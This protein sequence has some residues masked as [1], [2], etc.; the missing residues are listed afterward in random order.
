MRELT[1]YV[2]ATADG[3]IARVDGSFD[4]FLWEGEHLTDL[5]TNFPE[6]IPTHLR[7][8]LNVCGENRRY[9]TVLMG[10][11]TYEVG[12][13]RG[14]TSPYEHLRQYLFSKTMQASP[15]A[16]VELVKSDAAAFV[17]QLKQG[18]GKGIWLCGGGALAAALFDEIDEFILKVNPVMIGAGIPLFGGAVEAA[19]LRLMSSQT[20]P[21]G[22]VM[23]RY[24]RRDR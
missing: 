4:C 23:L 14:V 22:F 12:V 19:A 1:Y 3:F 16:S 8:A 9:D 5:C 2:A 15:D 24:R 6:T 17:R 20:Y 10:R 21:S 18:S 13:K 7:A 11:H